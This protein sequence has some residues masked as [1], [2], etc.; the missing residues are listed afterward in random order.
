MTMRMNALAA[1]ALVLSAGAAQAQ[2]KVTVAYFLEWPTANQ[3]AQLDETY[4]QEMGV[5]VDWRAFGNGNEM[6]Q[7][8]ASGDVQIAYSQG[9]VPFVVAVSSGL[10]L[11]LVGIAVSYAEAD[12]CIVR[13]DAGITQENAAEL[14]GKKVATPIRQRHALQECCARSTIWA[15]TPPRSTSCR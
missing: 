7:A 4:E 2:D 8:M 10:P 6:T 5:E 12:N 13:D 3:V 14:E 1:A 11:K 9:L 15:S